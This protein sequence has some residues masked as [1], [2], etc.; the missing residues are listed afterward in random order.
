M[1]VSTYSFFSIANFRTCGYCPSKCALFLLPL[2][3]S[4]PLNF[5]IVKIF[6]PIFPKFSIIVHAIR[7]FTK[8]L[9]M[10]A[11]RRRKHFYLIFT[12]EKRQNFL[13]VDKHIMNYN[14][15]IFGCKWRILQKWSLSLGFLD[16]SVSLKVDRIFYRA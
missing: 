1:H 14:S 6:I 4:F 2:Y 5:F 7:V 15:L 12:C 8:C 9:F 11:S 13:G 10:I 3:H 16:T